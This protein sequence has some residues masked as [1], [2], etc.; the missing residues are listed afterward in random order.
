[1]LHGVCPSLSDLA[2][3]RVIISRPIHVAAGGLFSCRWLGSQ[4]R[5][6]SPCI[7]VGQPFAA[8]ACLPPPG[9]VLPLTDQRA[10]TL[11]GGG[12]SSASLCGVPSV[13]LTAMFRAQ[14]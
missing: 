6:H 14:V 10:G 5:S 13:R 4:M 1:M 8:A 9:M 12:L 7:L 11:R 2:H 3:L